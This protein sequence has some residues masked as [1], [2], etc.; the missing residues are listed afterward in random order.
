M[1]TIIAYSLGLL[2]GPAIAVL[3][4]L[5]GKAEVTM[6]GYEVRPLS[7]ITSDETPTQR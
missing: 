4:A 1:K 6:Y 7:S 5:L 2:T 3:M